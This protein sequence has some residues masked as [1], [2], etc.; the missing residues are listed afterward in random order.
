[1][2]KTAIKINPDLFKKLEI[3]ASSLDISVEELVNTYLAQ[4]LQ[5][6]II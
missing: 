1:M 5:W 4:Y 2:L 3:E 6:A